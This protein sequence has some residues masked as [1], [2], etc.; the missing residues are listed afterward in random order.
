M[1][2]NK[3]RKKF[4][5]FFKKRGHKI[6]PSS[7]LIPDDPS[8]LLTTAGMQQFKPYYIGKADAM[9]DFGCL[10]VASVQKSFRTSDIGE[11]G[12]ESHLTFFEMLG[13]FSFGGYFKK[14]AIQYGYE[15]FKEIGLPIEY[16][17]VFGGDAEIPADEKSEKIWRE[18]GVTD[19]RRKGREDNFWGPTGSEGP[20]GPTTEI[21]AN[22]I[23]IWNIVFNEY[24]CKPD[25][26]FVPLEKPGV[27]TGMGLERLA[28]VLQKK[29][30]I[31]ET[32]LF[33][34]ISK[35]LPSGMDERIRR[36]FLDHIRAS[37]FL[38]SDGVQPS[39]KGAGF[40]LRR[41]L[42]RVMVHEYLIHK[43][44]KQYSG[45][46]VDVLTFGLRDYYF[47]AA[48]AAVDF[49][50]N[51]YQEL[52]WKTIHAVVDEEVQRFSRVVKDALRKMAKSPARLDARESFLLDQSY[53]LSFEVQKDIDPV[54]MQ[55]VTREKF[56][57]EF[58]KHQEISRAGIEKKF[59]GHGLL[60]DTGELKAADEEE[61]KKVT[62][63]HT[64]THLLNAALRKVL[65][66]QNIRQDGSDITAERTRFDFTFPRKLTPE[67]I[68]KVEDTV[69]EAVAKN[70]DVVREE[71]PYADAVKSGALHF[72]REKYPEQV[73]VYTVRDGKT[74]EVFSKELCGGP[75]VLCTSEI[76]RVKIIKEESSSAGVRRIR[77]ALDR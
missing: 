68:K 1:N 55:N 41:L 16:V 54:R 70:M 75:H 27:D 6:V 45:N 47:A 67:E 25:K 51:F 48:E 71:M 19:I 53:G 12:D 7:S 59:G 73:S 14:E 52:N 15:F 2:S 42:R 56:D 11:V 21:Y 23:E 9:K 74:G 29:K 76:G 28:M 31:F 77:A 58:K 36:I 22:G 30:N 46:N 60:L 32:D 62:R 24:Y 64:A 5:E 34:E 13:N 50:K 20:C 33:S 26:I 40:V 72:F 8:V 4:L 38:I 61:L 66:D 63:L 37:V 18:L 35:K 43:N 17:T 57:E 65:Q 39:N 69:N 10:N 49:Y 3:I 44:A